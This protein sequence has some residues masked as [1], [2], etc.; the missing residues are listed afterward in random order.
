ML[1]F[2][3][4]FPV[5]VQSRTRVVYVPPKSLSSPKLTRPALVRGKCK[6]AD[7]VIALMPGTE[8]PEAKTSLD[9]F[10]LTVAEHPIFFLGIPDIKGQ[11]KFSLYE[12]EGS[13]APKRSKKSIFTTN[14]PVNSDSG[15]I[16]SFRLPKNA[17]ILKIGKNYTWEFA[18]DEPTIRYKCLGSISRV[19]L[20][21]E[22]LE[23]LKRSQ[24][25]LE[26][27]VIYAKAG[28]WF[29]TIETLAKA[30]Y[31]QPKDLEIKAE[32]V[33]LLKSAK[34]DHVLPQPFRKISS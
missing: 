31:E 1:V 3:A 14:V 4:I 11:A 13:T 34:L 12:V 33:E 2:L 27:A 29:E 26:R 25:P 7:C 19:S 23:Q 28:I 8:P 22:I 6:K 10:P 21:G 16:I 20:P 32:W 24:Q 30:R 9:Y 5:A 17:P 18:F 15:E